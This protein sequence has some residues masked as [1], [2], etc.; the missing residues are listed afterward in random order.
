MGE[1]I[2]YDLDHFSESAAPLLRL[3]F[4]TRQLERI[5]DL[6]TNIAEDTIYMVDGKIVRHP[7][8]FN[9]NGDVLLDGAGRFRR[10]V[11]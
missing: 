5:A 11:P 7:S 10:I 3:T 2:Q 9:M 6:A 8:R 4:V 1:Q